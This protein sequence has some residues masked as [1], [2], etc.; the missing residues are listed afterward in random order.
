VGVAMIATCRSCGTRVGRPSAVGCVTTGLPAAVITGITIG[1]LVP[2]SQWFL[3]SA[4]PLWIVT[5]SLLWEGPQYLAM[6]Q[7]R[8]RPCPQC[9]ARDWERPEYSGFGL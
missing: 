6:F 7:N 8:S 3:L 5:T 2:I 1:F 9:K 4:I